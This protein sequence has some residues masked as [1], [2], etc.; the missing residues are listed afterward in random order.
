MKSWK[1]EIIHDFTFIARI[2][3]NLIYLTCK[4]ISWQLT[5]QPSFQHYLKWVEISGWTSPPLVTRLLAIVMQ[6]GIVRCS[7]NFIWSLVS[8]FQQGY[9]CEQV[10]VASH[11]FHTQNLLIL[12]SNIPYFPPQKRL[13]N[14]Q[15]IMLPVFSPI[16]LTILYDSLLSILRSS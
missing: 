8:L 11:T 9:P 5:E 1:M 15:V 4:S 16:L 13:V 2:S 7:P 10:H 6:S 12:C 14:S 3:S